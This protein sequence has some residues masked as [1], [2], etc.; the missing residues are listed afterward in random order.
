M[1]TYLYPTFANPDETR[2]AAV[3][4]TTLWLIEALKVFQLFHPIGAVC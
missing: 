1:S 4:S 2:V 3:V